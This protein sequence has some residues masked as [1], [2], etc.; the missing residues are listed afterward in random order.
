MLLSTH[1]HF[2]FYCHSQFFVWIN[3]LLFI[4]IK[5]LDLAWTFQQQ[6]QKQLKNF[7]EKTT[8]MYHLKKAFI[9][10]QLVSLKWKIS[11][12]RKSD[13]YGKKILTNFQST[14]HLWTLNTI[15]ISYML[16]ELCEAS[17]RMKSNR[18]KI[19]L[20]YSLST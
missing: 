5:T 10:T 1:V 19:I 14:L 8:K 20:F 2:I 9:T 12:I 18:K 13:V 4:K 6:Q 16:L 7:H 17:L 3:F 11:I 15:W